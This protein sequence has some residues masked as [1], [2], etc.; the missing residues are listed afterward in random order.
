VRGDYYRD[1]PILCEDGAPLIRI[2]VL[3]VPGPPEPLVE[4]RPRAGYGRHGWN[5]G[6]VVDRA[7]LLD[8]LRAECDGVT[9]GKAGKGR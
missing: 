3:S 6:V 1:H 8:L 5:R 7:R 9:H 4:W 2:P